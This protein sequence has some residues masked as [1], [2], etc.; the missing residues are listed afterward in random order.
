M[1]TGIKILLGIVC[2]L[3]V[4]VIVVLILPS[5]WSVESSVVIDA[6]PE[7]IHPLV[8][9]LHRWPDWTAPAQADRSLEYEYSGPEKGVGAEQRWSSSAGRGHT[10]ILSSDPATGVRLETAF[11]SDEIN[12][13]SSLTYAVEGDKTRVTWQG[14]GKLVPVVGALFLSSIEA[15]VENFYR[16]A[17]E[18]LKK[19]AEA[20]GPTTLP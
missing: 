19:L 6:P 12:S 9:D 10:R 1:S 13:E 5:Q 8:E 7:R 14:T 3:A 2:V 4:C 16:D 17:L 18:Q 11:L 15:G 20:S